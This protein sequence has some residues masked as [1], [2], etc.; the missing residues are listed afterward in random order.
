MFFN[1]AIIKYFR[2]VCINHITKCLFLSTY[3]AF[4]TLGQWFFLLIINNL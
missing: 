2:N 1:Q 4:T 3:T